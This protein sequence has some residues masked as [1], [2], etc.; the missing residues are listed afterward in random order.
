MGS[1]QY[2]KFITHHKGEGIRRMNE[3]EKDFRSGFCDAVDYIIE[4]RSTERMR[5]SDLQRWCEDVHDWR[6][7]CSGPPLPRRTLNNACLPPLKSYGVKFHFDQPYARGFDHGAYTTIRAIKNGATLSAIRRWR[8]WKLARWFYGDCANVIIAPELVLTQ[9]PKRPATLSDQ[10]AIA[11]TPS[12]P[13]PRRAC[14]SSL[15]AF[16]GTRK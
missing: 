4:L 15:Q 7:S 12:Q 5:L 8:G 11:A 2:V 10:D 16:A 14:H 3:D 9:R 6:I 1:L 13:A